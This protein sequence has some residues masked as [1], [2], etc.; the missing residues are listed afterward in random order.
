MTT[1]V[2]DRNEVFFLNTRFY[3]IF[4]VVLGNLLLPVLTSDAGTYAVGFTI[5]TFHIPVF[6][7]VTGFF[8]RR[9]P[10]NPDRWGVIVKIGCQYVIF[11]TLYA[12]L[13]WMFFQTSGTIYSFWAPYW[14]LWFLFSHV[15]WKLL[16]LLFVRFKHPLVLAVA[17]GV[18]AGYLPVDGF[19]LSLSRTFVFFPFFV[20][21]YY[22]PVEKLRKLARSPAVKI[23][24][25]LW[26]AALLAVLASSPLRLDIGW[27]LGSITNAG[28]QRPEWYAGIYRL[29]I[30]GLEAS[31]G[32]AFLMLQTDRDSRITDW[33]KRS[34]YV[35][36]LHGLAIKLLSAAGAYTLAQRLLPLSVLL[37]A[38]VVLTLLLVQPWVA[39]L[40]HAVIEPDPAILLRFSL[41]K[42]LSFRLLPRKPS[43][44][45]RIPGK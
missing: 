8:S 35:F 44:R 31:A 17:L 41:F 36:L 39:R 16:L 6:V 1:P 26:L 7:L 19:W 14:M 12:V 23:G 10:E 32:C 2:T 28:L 5:F 18:L 25:A 11:Q 29:G 43:K 3:L 15:C 20:A 34:V 27:L 33:G 30:Y 45:L 37:P 13:D 40:T 9:F 24:A 21:G 4:L 38:A 42:G 22:C